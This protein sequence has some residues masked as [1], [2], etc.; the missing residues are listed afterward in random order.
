MTDLL[1]RA[2]ER[3]VL[4]WRARLKDHEAAEAKEHGLP[5][6]HPEL[7]TIESIRPL[8][9]DRETT[10]RE[11]AIELQIR[12][13]LFSALEDIRRGDLEHVED[14]ISYALLCVI[15]WDAPP[16]LAVTPE[17]HQEVMKLL[18]ERRARLAKA[19]E[20][21]ARTSPATGAPSDT[22]RAPPP[23]PPSTRDAES[24]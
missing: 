3:D 11:R 17:E 21:I 19:R 16:P 23:P 5:V 2:W 20:E 6:G 24:R 7:G 12:T 8:L 22:E 18:G 15:G 10:P 4:P 14:S 1:Q 13:M 9:G